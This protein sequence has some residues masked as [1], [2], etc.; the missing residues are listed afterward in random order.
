M[1]PVPMV[2]K[3]FCLLRAHLFFLLLGE[4][5][6]HAPRLRS[7]IFSSTISGCTDFVFFAIIFFLV[8]RAP[9]LSFFFEIR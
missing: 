7:D 4:I 3:V 6:G 8:L 9:A 1:C 2:F 5:P